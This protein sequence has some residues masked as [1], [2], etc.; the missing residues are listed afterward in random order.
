MQQC[1]VMVL[2]PGIFTF[3]QLYNAY[4]VSSGGV[5][6]EIPAVFTC[7]SFPGQRIPNFIQIV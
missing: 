4:V 6:P 2:D 3:Q 1:D 7:D 5:N